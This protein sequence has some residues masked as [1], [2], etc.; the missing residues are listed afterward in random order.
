MY[1][2][3]AHGRN[4]FF[5]HCWRNLRRCGG[6]PRV[7][8]LPVRDC[9]RGCNNRD[10][11]RPQ[12]SAMN[13]TKKTFFER[14]YLVPAMRTFG[15]WVNCPHALTTPTI[16]FTTISRFPWNFLPEWPLNFF[17]IKIHQVIGWVQVPSDP[18]IPRPPH[19]KDSF[20]K[21]WRQNLN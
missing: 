5:R 4:I 15:P 6:P 9:A 10:Q 7:Q 20:F 17:V 13:V 12:I 1:K 18:P 19:W 3:S 2:Y 14:F 21:F 16:Y 8:G 11:T